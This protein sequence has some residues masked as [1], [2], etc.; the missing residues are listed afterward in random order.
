MTCKY[1]INGHGHLLPEPE[2]IPAF[3]KAQKLFWLD[4]DRQFMRQ[5]D[6]KRPVTDPS[7][8]LKEKLEWME[9]SRIDHEVILNLS[10]LYANGLSRELALSTIKF[11]NDFNASIQASHP[12]KFTCGFVLQPAYLD[13]ALQEMERCVEKLGM[14]L[15]C[16]PTHYQDP[17]G[18]WRSVANEMTLPIW[19]LADKYGLA[20]QIHPYDAPK[21]IDLQNRYWRF[22]LVWMCAQTADTFHCY[23]LLDFPARFANT[24]VCFAHGNQFGQVNIG[25]RRQGF[26][27]RPDLFEGTIDPIENFNSSN[28]FF[29]TLVHDV[30]S[31][32]LL[33]DRQ[34]VDQIIA[35]LDDPYPLGEMASVPH[36]YTGKVID[37]AVERGFIT[38]EDRC[39][40][41]HANVLRWLYGERA[42]EFPY[43]P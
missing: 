40:I 43:S 21:M 17:I 29:D 34:G 15:L 5:G 27:G 36:S 23:S 7:F 20:I 4:D 1:R 42:H 25:R 16:L 39:N 24:R 22:H 14:R 10:Q 26:M 19:E 12:D 31:F 11:Q 2:Q 9:E 8:F 32:R 6:W 13:D 35:G 33:I 30:L 28:V 38:A 41:W 37:E 18:Q 3:M